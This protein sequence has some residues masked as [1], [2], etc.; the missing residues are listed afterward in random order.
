MRD[1]THGNWAPRHGV[2]DDAPEALRQLD[3]LPLPAV[4]RISAEGSSRRDD[5]AHPCEKGLTTR[6][7]PN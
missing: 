1:D 7:G 4:H 3:R 2:A 6:T 5:A